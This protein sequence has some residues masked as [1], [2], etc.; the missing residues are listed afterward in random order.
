MFENADFRPAGLAFSFA[1][2]PSVA[3]RR[4]LHQ[5]RPRISTVPLTVRRC[6]WR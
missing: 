6:I 3:R 5:W 1:F 4:I 2:A